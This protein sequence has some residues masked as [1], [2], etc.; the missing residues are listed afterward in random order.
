MKPIHEQEWVA[1]VEPYGT[2]ERVVVRTDDGRTVA[3]LPAYDPKSLK[4]RRHNAALISAAPDMARALIQLHENVGSCICAGPNLC[5]IGA[6][7]RKAGVI[8]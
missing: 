2:G 4:A 5:V 6:A 3:H 1:G 8:P 7:L